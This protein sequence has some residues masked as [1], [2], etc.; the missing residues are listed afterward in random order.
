M[1]DKPPITIDKL[2]G[3]D[4]MMSALRDVGYT[5]QVI[6]EDS[7]ARADLLRRSLKGKKKI[8]AKDLALIRESRQE[9][10]MIIA[11]TGMKRPEKHEFSGDISVSVIDRYPEDQEGEDQ[12]E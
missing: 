5:A 2:Y 12:E 8:K 7:K 1:T 11:V 4:P 9:A 10:E 6:A 3:P